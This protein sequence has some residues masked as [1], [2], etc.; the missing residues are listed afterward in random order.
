[1]RIQPL[2]PLQNGHSPKLSE[3]QADSTFQRFNVSTGPKGI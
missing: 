1:M 2:N 3:T